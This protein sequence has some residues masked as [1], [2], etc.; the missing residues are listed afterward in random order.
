[1]ATFRNP[2][3]PENLVIIAK[4]H[5]WVKEKILLDG[6]AII[7]VIEV[8]C[9]DPGCMDKATRIL[10]TGI[11]KEMKQFSIHKPLVY[12]RKPDIEKLLSG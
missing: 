3:D 4:I 10:I 7:Q 12:V 11:D 9:A 6:N 2:H 5:E 1:M 8:D